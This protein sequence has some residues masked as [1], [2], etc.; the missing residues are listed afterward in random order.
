MLHPLMHPINRNHQCYQVINKFETI[1]DQIILVAIATINV[2]L[3]TITVGVVNRIN[4]H[5]TS[6]IDV[7]THTI[8]IIITHLILVQLIIIISRTKMIAALNLV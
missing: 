3:A 2:I 6:M 1:F 4:L 5:K 7:R 8:I